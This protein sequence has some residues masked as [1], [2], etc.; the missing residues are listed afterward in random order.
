MTI[1]KLTCKPTGKS[2][3]L[4]DVLEI[5]KDTRQLREIKVRVTDADVI[6][7]LGNNI[8]GKG[9]FDAGGIVICTY[10]TSIP[11]PGVMYCVL[12]VSE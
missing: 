10:E 4:G 1:A 3:E 8:N 5:I 11:I 9:R 7:A 12:D 6:E 2:C